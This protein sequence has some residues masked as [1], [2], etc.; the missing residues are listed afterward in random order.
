MGFTPSDSLNFGIS[1]IYGA[2]KDDN[3]HDRR[4]VID[5]DATITPADALTIGAE[6]NFGKE[7]ESSVKVAGDDAEWFGGLIMAHYDFTDW[8]GLTLRYDYFDDEEGY[9]FGLVAEGDDAGKAVKMQSFTIAPTFAIADGAGF[10]LEYRYD[11]A[12]KDFFAAADGKYT[13]HNHTVAFEFTY[14]F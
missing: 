10:L 2:E 9:S 8:M 11:F 3:N 6:I 5:L 4:L 7:D 13:D 1:G 14:S 12:D